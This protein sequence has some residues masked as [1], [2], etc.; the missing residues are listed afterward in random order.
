[1]TS[2]IRLIY[3]PVVPIKCPAYINAWSSN[4]SI[5]NTI[6]VYAVAEI[7]EAIHGIVWCAYQ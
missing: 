4:M 3:I 6:S 1:M 2:H 5:V 7:D